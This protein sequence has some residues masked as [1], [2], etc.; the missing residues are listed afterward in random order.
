MDDI[1]ANTLLTLSDT[2]KRTTAPETT[3]GSRWEVQ[4][5]AAPCREWL[6]LFKLAGDASL[7]V[8]RAPQ[9]VVFDRASAVFKSDEEHVEQWIALID[10]WI[11]VTDGRYRAS[12]DEASR[13]LSV[14]LDTEAQQRERIQQLNERFKNL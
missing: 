6:D 1:T 11:V 10:Q 13:V 2:I 5:S 3:N 12:L 8:V 9:R 7:G 14:R 4:L